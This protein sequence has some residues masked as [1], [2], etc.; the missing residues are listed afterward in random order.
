MEV[1]VILQAM[2]Y[3]SPKA[4]WNLAF[5]VNNPTLGQNKGDI[6]QLCLF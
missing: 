1:V 3:A 6:H 2:Q 5:G 4:L